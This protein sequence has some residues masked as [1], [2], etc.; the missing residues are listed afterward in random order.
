MAQVGAL[1]GAGIDEDSLSILFFF[2]NRGH[3][4]EFLFARLSSFLISLFKAVNK[5]R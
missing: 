5:E 4:T 3:L 1:A 2:L